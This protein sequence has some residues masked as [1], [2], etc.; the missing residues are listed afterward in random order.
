MRGLDPQARYRAYILEVRVRGACGSGAWALISGPS[1]VDR[2]NGLPFRPIPEAKL[3]LGLEAPNRIEFSCESAI[4][5][6]S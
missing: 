4:A 3:D 2:D 1:Q 5:F 6:D